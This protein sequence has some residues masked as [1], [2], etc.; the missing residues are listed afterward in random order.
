MQR[1]PNVTNNASSHH[2]PLRSTDHVS[3]IEGIS[4]YNQ[5]KK[6][7][8]ETNK[9]NNKLNKNYQNWKKIG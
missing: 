6:N 8:D 5:Q 4:K 3:K 1:W 2:A 9:K 7:G